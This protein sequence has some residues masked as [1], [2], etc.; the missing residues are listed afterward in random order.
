MINSDEEMTP[1]NLEKELF[2]EE[3]EKTE[4]NISKGN[5]EKTNNN[6]K[7]QIDDSD[8]EKELEDSDDTDFFYNGSSNGSKSGPP[9]NLPTL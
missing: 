7:K 5:L 3:K 8:F 9:P 1:E 6:H 2:T 4:N